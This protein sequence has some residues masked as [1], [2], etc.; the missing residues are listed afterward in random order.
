MLD[1]P[2]P[3]QVKPGYLRGGAMPSPTSLLQLVSRPSNASAASAPKA[4]VGRRDQ[5]QLGQCPLLPSQSACTWASKL[6]KTLFS[7]HTMEKALT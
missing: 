4:V 3:L 6:K 1:N 5:I 2:E 7:K